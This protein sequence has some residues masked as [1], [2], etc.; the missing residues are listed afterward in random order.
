[1]SRISLTLLCVF[2]AIP[3]LAFAAEP[4]LATVDAMA[5]YAA[6]TGAGA[7]NCRSADGSG[8]IIVC[9]KRRESDR[10]RLPF[11]DERSDGND[12]AII[13]GEIRPASVQRVRVGG[14]SVVLG[15]TCNGGVAIAAIRGGKFNFGTN[16]ESTAPVALKILGYLLAPNQSGPELPKPRN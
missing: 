8:D 4:E 10:Q 7:S 12:E 15:Q 9:A 14:C 16:G 6:L 3:R 13:K 1:M 11:A 2:S 5:R